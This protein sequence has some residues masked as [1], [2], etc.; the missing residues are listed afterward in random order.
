[1]TLLLPIGC[2]SVLTLLSLL[3]VLKTYL[4]KPALC[5]DSV[6]KLMLSCWRRDTKDRPSFQDLHRQLQEAA[7]EE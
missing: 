5:P 2:T 3:F 1:M 7:T 6:Y 4:P